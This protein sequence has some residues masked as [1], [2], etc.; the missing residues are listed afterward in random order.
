MDLFKTILLKTFF[1]LTSFILFTLP[2]Y[3]E[4]MNAV[5]IF[6]ETAPAVVV[7]EADYGDGTGFI[8]D[9]DGTI[10]TNWH[11]AQNSSKINV[12]L[13]DGTS[14]PVVLIQSYD[15]L[16]DLCLLKINPTTE[17]PV[18]KMGTYDKLETGE[19]VYVIGNPVG[20]NYS[21]SDGIVSRKEENVIG[22]SIQFTS[23]TSPGSSGSP[24]LNDKGEAVGVVVSGMA[25]GL[26]NSVYF[27]ISSDD[28]SEL[29]SVRKNLSLSDFAKTTEMTSLIREGYNLVSEG[30]YEEAYA[31]YI[32]V[33]DLRCG[34]QDSV[35]NECLAVLDIIFQ[36]AQNETS[37]NSKAQNDLLIKK[38]RGESLSS[39]EMDEGERKRKAMKK[40]AQTT[41]AVIDKCGG[42]KG[43]Y[44]K[45][46]TL[47]PE[48]YYNLIQDKLC[49]AYFNL[50]MEAVWSQDQNMFEAIFNKIQEAFP[51]HQ[52]L[53]LLTDAKQNIPGKASGPKEEPGTH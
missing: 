24:L 38:A 22:R 42:L 8:I 37:S 26:A 17:L 47:Y 46:I 7:V 29:R 4:E 44:E 53:Q 50:A 12:Y 3:A 30:K 33:F 18:I 45:L 5:Q 15:I 32:R 35:N 52:T 23:P 20:L 1:V 2:V 21:I 19:K 34:Q 11:V 14:F 25:T 49:A 36:A 41:I 48:E 39:E 28:V 40:W 10:V 16:K 6:K 13:K 9:K 51:N 31:I 43:F 27:A